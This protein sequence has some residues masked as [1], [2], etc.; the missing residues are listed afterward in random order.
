M[1][2]FFKRADPKPGMSVGEFDCAEGLA[3]IQAA[4][5][6]LSIHNGK[7]DWSN[8]VPKLIL[9]LPRTRLEVGPPSQTSPVLTLAHEGAVSA[10]LADALRVVDIGG[11]YRLCIDVSRVYIGDVAEG[12]F[13][14]L[15]DFFKVAGSADDTLGL[16][17]ENVV[18]KGDGHDVVTELPVTEYSED[19]LAY[20]DG[21]FAF[22]DEA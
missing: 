20:P 22:D 9:P 10:A 7:T 11:S 17:L 3:R 1:G 12:V 4:L 16:S 2:R 5:N 21:A 13:R 6:G 15:A 14:P 19:N 18:A 8:D